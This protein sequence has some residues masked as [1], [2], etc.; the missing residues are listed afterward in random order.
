MK[1]GDFTELAKS[2]INRP[3]YSLQIITAILKYMDY[4]K[5]TKFTVADVGAGT[6]K[7][8][9]VLLEMGLNVPFA[10]EPN[11]QMREEGINY[12]SGHPI[13]WL[14][15][16]G[17]VT[18]LENNSVNWLTM[19][20]SFHW[21]DPTKSLPEFSRVLK[22]GGY[23]TAIWN[24]R[25]IGSSK[26]HTEIEDIIYKISPNIQR[27][28][29]GSKSHTKNW[30]EILTSTGHFKDVILMEVDHTEIMSINR[31]MGAWRSVNDIRAQAGEE[32]F[33]LILKTIEDK[34]KHMKEITVP[35]KMRAWTSQKI[36]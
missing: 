25:N 1:Q 27:V 32:K 14:K 30:D 8:T 18:N 26:L 21:T 9:K 16:S 19:A 5:Q 22:P 36:G 3:A 35:Y 20:S 23:F 10:V 7:L 29:S 31:Y 4:D 2:Y 11:D 34:I 13:K 33:N 24:P 15:G 17:E 12:T 28:S 6:G